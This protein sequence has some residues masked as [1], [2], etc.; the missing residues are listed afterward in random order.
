MLR[1]LTIEGGHPY[2]WTCM[3][4]D[5]PKVIIAGDGA[6]ISNTGTTPLLVTVT[7]HQ[8]H[9]VTVEVPPQGSVVWHPPV[10]WRS[11]TFNAPG[12][13]EEFRMVE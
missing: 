4:V 3:K 12:H 8:G 1:P 10:G 5:P 7:G 11:A 13:P 9:Q 6:T 2:L